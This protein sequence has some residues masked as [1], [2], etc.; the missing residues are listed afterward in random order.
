MVGIVVLVAL[1]VLLLAPGRIFAGWRRDR[2]RRTSVSSSSPAVRTAPE[3]IERKVTTLMLAGEL[4]GP[5]YRIAMAELAAHSPIDITVSLM[6]VARG[7][8]GRSAERL[9]RALPELAPATVRAAVDLA[10]CGADT[11]ELIRLLHLTC[12]QALRITTALSADDPA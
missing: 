1:L 12:P 2:W 6:L 3:E 7:P 8:A 11:D 10:R 9:C 4:D 5:S